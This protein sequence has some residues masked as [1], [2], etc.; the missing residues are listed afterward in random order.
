MS[1]LP[2][3]KENSQHRSFLENSHHVV[4]TQFAQ[5]T[6]VHEPSFCFGGEHSIIL[7]TLRIQKVSTPKKNYRKLGKNKLGKLGERFEYPSQSWKSR[8]GN[9]IFVKTVLSA[10]FRVKS[11]FLT[12]RTA[13]MIE[14]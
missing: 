10:C 2:M 6:R 5:M 13:R 4:K 7:G 14:N 9:L 11:R 8:I 1:S 3:W 12:P